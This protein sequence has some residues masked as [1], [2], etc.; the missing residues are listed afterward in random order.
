MGGS[1]RQIVVTG[2]SGNVGTA[3]LRRLAG[4][5]HVTGI[6]R[7]RPPATAPYDTAEWLTLDLSQDDATDRLLP[8]MA[9][10]DAVV[11]LA[12]QIQPGRDRA[13]LRRTN[14]GGTRAVV[15]AAAVAGV[16]HVIH[17]SS[18]GAYSAGP[19]ER[20]RVDESWPTN[21]IPSS[22]YSVDK[23]AAERIVAQISG[24][25]VSVLR[26]GL[27]LQPDAASEISRYFIGP[28]V[29]VTLLHPSLLR[30]APFPTALATQFVHADDVAAAI[31]IILD[32]RAAGAFNVVAEPVLDRDHF[33]D[34]FGGAAPGLPR[35]VLRSLVDLSWRMRLQP[36][37]AGWID[38]AFG[39]PLL[40]ASR[41]RELGWSPEHTADETLRRFVDALR[42]RA[43]RPGPLLRPRRLLSHHDTS[44]ASN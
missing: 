17:M 35:G 43:G 24:R 25:V 6:A 19:A 31:G 10:A 39:S 42:R 38:L 41:L 2:A 5:A 14:Q 36:T 37:D 23:A 44:T 30:L 21:G 8:A 18:V 32:Q 20:T 13:Q 4:T 7:R 27:I 3:L 1:K 15:E 22:S 33:R 34:L 26:P 28:F 29:P 12:W 40:D 16:S 9:G 11:H